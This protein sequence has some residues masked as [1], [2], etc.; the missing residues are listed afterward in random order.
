MTQEFG[1]LKNIANIGDIIVIN[2]YPGRKFQVESFTHSIIYSSDYIEESIVYDAFDIETDEY[3]LAFQED[4]T[5][6][7]RKDT[8]N[9]ET[10]KSEKEILSKTEQIDRLLDEI[11]DYQYLIKI[12]GDDNESYKNKI[13]EI[14][15]KLSAL[16][17]KDGQQRKG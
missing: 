2:G 7:E 14:K 15:N 5:V 8:I 11:N 4:I 17:K 16:I 1:K 13:E 6:I 10:K 12:F 9:I 3:E